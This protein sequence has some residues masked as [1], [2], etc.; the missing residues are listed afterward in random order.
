MVF[1]LNQIGDVKIHYTGYAV[2]NNVGEKSALTS[3]AE[4]HAEDQ[5]TVK[6]S[7]DEN[8]IME[9]LENVL[10]NAIRYARKE[11]EV[12]S[13]YDSETGEFNLTVRD[14]GNGFSREQQ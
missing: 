8:I 12:M 6:I 10:S 4:D 11:I 7:A 13:D 2:K 1:A 9:V 14:D 3:I 5:R